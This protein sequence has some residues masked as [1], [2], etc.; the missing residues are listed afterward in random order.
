MKK[1]ILSVAFMLAAGATFAQDNNSD[2]FQVGGAQASSVSQDGKENNATVRQG[3]LPGQSLLSNNNYAQISQTGE[4]NDAFISQSNLQNDAYQTQ[5]GNDNS[6]TIWQDQLNPDVSFG[7]DLAVQ[8]QVGNN[9][10]ATIDQGTSGN[11]LPDTPPFAT[12]A[13]DLMDDYV[14]VPVNPHGSNEAYQTQSGNYGIAYASQ[15]G[16]DNVSSQ[17]QVGSWD[18][19]AGSENES[20]HYQY[21]AGNS[22]TSYQDGKDLT[23]NTLQMG[24]TNSSNVAQYGNGHDATTVQF[25]LSN[26]STVLQTN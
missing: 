5:L 3:V 15:G 17:T 22:A 1:V 19:S 10:T 7:Y 9:N 16:V 4:Y 6:A 20:N 21:G 23:N 26:T 12:A 25:G 18:I 11:T 2:V 24:F 13:I 8:N 14:P